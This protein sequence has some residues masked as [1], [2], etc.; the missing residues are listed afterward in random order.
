MP[1]YPTEEKVIY[2]VQQK[3]EQ[4]GSW[5]KGNDML[6][7]SI[8]IRSTNPKVEERMI[9]GKCVVNAVFGVRLSKEVCLMKII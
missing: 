7:D 5:F 6:T 2:L 4:S 9:N 8:Y 1:K 3:E